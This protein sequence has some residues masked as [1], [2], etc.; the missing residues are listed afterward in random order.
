M[1]K[2]ADLQITLTEKRIAGLAA[3]TGYSYDFL[4]DIYLEC[5]ADGDDFKYFE[6]VTLEHDW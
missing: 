3:K 4:Y 6:G 5:E 1:S 2:M